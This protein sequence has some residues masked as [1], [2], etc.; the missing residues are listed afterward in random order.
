MYDKLSDYM[1]A[2]RERQGLRSDRALARLMEIPQP[3]VS[4]WRN[5]KEW[6]SDAY[7]Q[8]IAQLAGADE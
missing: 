6:P 8:R 1:D 7:M 3:Y 5:G 2:A 4:D